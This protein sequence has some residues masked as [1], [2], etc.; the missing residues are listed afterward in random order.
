MILGK[1]SWKLNHEADS[2]RNPSAI[3]MKKVFE[4]AAIL[5]VLLTVV[6]CASTGLVKNASP[7]T[8]GKPFELDYI[9]VETSSS[10]G[11]LEGEQK[12]LK[13]HIISGLNE[14]QLF[15]GVSGNRA[16]VSLG[17]GIT[18]AA[19]IK[20]IKKVSNNAR[21]WLGAM[22]GQARISVQ[23]KLSDLNNGQVMQTFEVEGKSSGGSALAGATD[24][25]IEL[26]AEQVVGEVVGFNAQTAQ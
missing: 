17:S 10:M 7:I 11:G 18:I 24:E 9:Y 4:M 15:K 6:G 5:F 12:L 22:A 14:R 16:D 21:L 1:R 2:T 8:A 23:V 26:A 25:A 13:D 20:A 3:F 19:E